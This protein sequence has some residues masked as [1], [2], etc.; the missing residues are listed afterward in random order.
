MK[1]SDKI[2]I[3]IIVIAGAIAALLWFVLGRIAEL[4]FMS[5]AKN[6]CF[7]ISIIAILLVVIACVGGRH[8]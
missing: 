1:K 5:S 3:T 7:L 8:E 4:I 2:M 6:L